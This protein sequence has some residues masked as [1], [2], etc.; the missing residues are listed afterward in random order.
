MILLFRP[1]ETLLLGVIW[2]EVTHSFRE[3]LLYVGSRN[4]RLVYGAGQA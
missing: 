4:G 1:G 3:R 2:L